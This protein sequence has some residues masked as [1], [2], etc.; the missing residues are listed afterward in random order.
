MHP[1]GEVTARRLFTN[2][3]SLLLK[4]FYYLLLAIPFRQ[5]SKQVFLDFNYTTTI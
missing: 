5:T 4:E 1:P 2:R 3:N